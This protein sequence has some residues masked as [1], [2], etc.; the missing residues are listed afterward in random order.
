MTTREVLNNI[1]DTLRP[2][3][4]DMLLE[5]AESLP[6][7]ERVPPSISVGYAPP[8]NAD[9]SGYGEM[10]N[11]PG[12]VIGMGENGGSDDGKEATIPVMITVGTYSPGEV[13]TD[14]L[15]KLNNEGYIDL[16][17]LI[18]R[19]RH[20]L[21]A[22]TVLKRT[23]IQRPVQWGMYQEQPYPYWY[24]W[25]SFEAMVASVEMQERLRDD[26]LTI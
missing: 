14:G 24:G 16:L 10:Y 7:A 22:L 3:L 5:K 4:A 15:V 19:V 17:N 6:G 1:A 25:L 13:G 26:F 9:M 12:V 23:T 8:R 2:K 21:M 18:E 11:V 20:V